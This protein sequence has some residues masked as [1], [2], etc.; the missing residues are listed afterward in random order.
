MYLRPHVYGCMVVRVDGSCPS[1]DEEAAYSSRL[2]I[3]V[4]SVGK[5]YNVRRLRGRE[6][7]K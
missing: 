5:P 2:K 7:E 1:V 3:P 4:L 6:A